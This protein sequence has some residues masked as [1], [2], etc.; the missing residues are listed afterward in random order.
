MPKLTEQ[1]ALT[2][3]KEI[4][5]RHALAYNIR[6]GLTA[7]F[8]DSPATSPSV[9]CWC[10]SYVSQPGEFDQHDYFLFLADATGEMLHILGPH[11]KLRL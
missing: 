2:I 8:T 10:I 3:A 7:E 6:E 9:P 5:Q 11:G 1:Q 4:L